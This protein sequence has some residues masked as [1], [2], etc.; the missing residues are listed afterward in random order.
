MPSIFKLSACFLA[1]LLLVS[2]QTLS[3]EIYARDVDGPFLET[4]EAHMQALESEHE[5]LMERHYYEKRDILV[6]IHRIRKVHV[7]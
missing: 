1:C 2:A 4:R 7:C 6:S 5:A 3:T